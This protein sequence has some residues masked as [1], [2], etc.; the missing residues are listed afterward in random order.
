[1]PLT[2]VAGWFLNAF[3]RERTICSAGDGRISV[4]GV[5][6]ATHENVATVERVIRKLKRLYKQGRQIER[7]QI[8]GRCRGA[9]ERRLLCEAVGRMVLSFVA[10]L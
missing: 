9:H 2:E 3:G 7:K 1:M 4:L 8:L 5:T 6:C 10:T